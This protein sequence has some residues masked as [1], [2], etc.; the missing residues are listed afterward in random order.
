MANTGIHDQV[1]APVT[2]TPM[3]AIG[4]ATVDNDATQEAWVKVGSGASTDIVSP[5]VFRQCQLQ[6][7]ELDGTPA[8]FPIGASVTHADGLE[9]IGPNVGIERLETTTSD[10][11]SY[12]GTSESLTLDLSTPTPTLVAG[13]AVPITESDPPGGTPFERLSRFRCDGLANIP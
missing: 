4:G 7:V 6:R 3:T 10:G 13:A 5:F 2:G 1:I 9:C 11:S 8:E 12:T